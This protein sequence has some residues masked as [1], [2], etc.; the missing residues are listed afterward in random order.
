MKNRSWKLIV[1]A[2]AVVIAL[3]IAINPEVRAIMLLAEVLGFDV[4]VFLL[5]TQARLI[6]PMIGPMTTVFT[7]GICKVGAALSG[8]ALQTSVS[9][10][11]LRLFA[12]LVSPLLLTL[13]FLMQC[14]R[15]ITT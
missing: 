12:V 11:P 15:K 1:F 4:L 7:R 13:A 10:P 14:N 6:F 8:H 3:A 5:A 9:L 2:A